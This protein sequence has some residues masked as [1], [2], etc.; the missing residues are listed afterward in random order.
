[1]G[2][3]FVLEKGF[4]KLIDAGILF[5]YSITAIK[6]GLFYAK[7]PAAINLWEVEKP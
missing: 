4:K 2:L 7:K 1:M 3:H 5:C 6:S